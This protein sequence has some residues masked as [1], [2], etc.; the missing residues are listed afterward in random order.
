MEAG[1]DKELATKVAEE[2]STIAF[3]QMPTEEIR[4]AVIDLLKRFNPK[5]AKQYSD[6]RKKLK[7]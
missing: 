2:V 3:V 7:A 5:I 4:E 1:A 6:Y